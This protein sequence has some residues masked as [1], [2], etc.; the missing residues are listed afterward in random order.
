MDVP[1]IIILVFSFLFALTV[2]EASH[3]W[4]AYK[5]GDPTAYSLGRVSL[6][7][8]A[9]IDPIGTVIFPFI[10]L[11]MGL[12]PDNLPIFCLPLE[13]SVSPTHTPS[14]WYRVRP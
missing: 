7:P 1:S 3:A 4:A 6:N 10:M 11:I 14:S 13:R 12:V 5:L 8:L 2:H 9:H